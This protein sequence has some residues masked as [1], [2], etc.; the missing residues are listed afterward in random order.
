MIKNNILILV[1]P[2]ISISL[3]AIIFVIFYHESAGFD[4]YISSIILALSVGYLS[5]FGSFREI[6][7]GNSAALSNFGVQIFF[8][9]LIFL[10]SI[11]AFA[12]SVFEITSL[13]IAFLIISFTLF[14]LGGIVKIFVSQTLR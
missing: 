5:H 13:S 1:P 8:S 3:L 11:V 2:L 7:E 6:K 14:L 12:F 10:S 9:T 4:F